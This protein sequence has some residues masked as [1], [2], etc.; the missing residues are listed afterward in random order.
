MPR[1]ATG[2][3][4]GLLAIALAAG[5]AAAG[6]DLAAAGAAGS[7]GPF[8]LLPWWVPHAGTRGAAAVCQRAGPCRRAS[9][10]CRAPHAAPLQRPRGV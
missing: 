10:A 5:A 2:L 1:P 7:G 3:L 9:R 4:L 8:E 6:A